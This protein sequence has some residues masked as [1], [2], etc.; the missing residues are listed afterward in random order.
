YMNWIRADSGGKPLPLIQLNKSRWKISG[1][2]NGGRVE[3]EMFSD[4]P[5]PYGAQLNSHHAFFN[6][7]EI[8]CYIEGERGDPA[9]VEF[10]GVPS[11]WKIAT[12]LPQQGSSF[13]AISYDQL[14]DSPVEIGA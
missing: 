14:V 1:A 9:E 8:L 12:P 10:R 5:S 7:A 11:G 3:Y 6:L 2:E 13:S 4:N